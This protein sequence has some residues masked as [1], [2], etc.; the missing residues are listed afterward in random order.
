MGMPTPPNRGNVKLETPILLK[1]KRFILNR[2]LPQFGQKSWQTQFGKTFDI[3]TKVRLN[4]NTLRGFVW[5][6]SQVSINTFIFLQIF[7]FYNY[8]K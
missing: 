3:Y 1:C 4:L 8:Y 5:T 2:D 6:L 7:N